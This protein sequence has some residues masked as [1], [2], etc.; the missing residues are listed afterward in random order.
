LKYKGDISKYLLKQLLYQ[1][2]PETFFNRNK[3]GFSIPLDQWLSGPL[4]SLIDDWLSDEMLDRSPLINKNEVKKYIQEFKNGKTY[5][6]NRIWALIVW[7]MF[8]YHQS[9]NND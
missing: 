8:T 5:L 1:Y 9:K 3:W 4:Q 6:Y 2:I 7:Q